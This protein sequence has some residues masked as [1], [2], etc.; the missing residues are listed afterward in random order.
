[1]AQ[2]NRVCDSVE[3]QQFVEMGFDRDIAGMVLEQCN[4]NTTAAMDY[5]LEMQTE[6]KHDTELSNNRTESTPHKPNRNIFGMLD[7][8]PK[9]GEEMKM[10]NIFPQILPLDAPHALQRIQFIDRIYCR[11]IE[12]QLNASINHNANN[13]GDAIDIGISDTYNFSHFLRDFRQITK[14]KDLLVEQEVSGNIMECDS[15]TCHRLRR[16]DRG[17]SGSSYRNDTDIGV[18]EEFFIDD[19]D[20]DFTAKMKEITTQRIMDS[21]HCYLVHSIRIPPSQI[22]EKQKQLMALGKD[23]E[24]DEC[25]DY[26]TEAIRILMAKRE[27][28]PRFRDCNRS[29]NGYNKFMTYDHYGAVEQQTLAL[30]DSMNDRNDDEKS[31][32]VSNVSSIGTFLEELTTEMQK[33]KIGVDI[34]TLSIFHGFVERENLDSETVYDDLRVFEDSNIINELSSSLDMVS[35]VR[36]IRCFHSIVTKFITKRIGSSDAYS[37]GYRFFYWPF[38]CDNTAPGRTVF[39]SSG[40]HYHTEMNPGYTLGDWYIGEKYANF[41]EEALHNQSARITGKQ[42]AMTWHKARIQ[43]EEW[44]Q[45]GDQR[46]CGWYSFGQNMWADAY[47][48]EDG[49]LV[50]V[51]HIMALLFYCDFTKTCGE[52]CKTFRKIWVFESDDSLKRRHSEV[53]IWARLLRELIECFGWTMSDPDANMMDCHVFYHGIAG[54]MVFNRTSNFICGPL[55]TSSGL[56]FHLCCVNVD[57]HFKNSQ[58]TMK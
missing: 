35:R 39:P 47:G 5:L 13:I 12:S 36:D 3:I 27:Q 42:W 16:R 31:P 53:A 11:W 8:E 4:F 21:V 43:L 51:E 30:N 40:M 20:D 10:K 33:S 57:T 2:Q 1:M 49:S 52:F 45:S 50:T 54:S 24:E 7:I 46:V 29:Q 23:S 17:R 56:L 9:D 28:L 22:E 38:Y 58:N 25:H 18:K 19:D 44:R 15:S 6:Q 32:S 37:S 41:K 26:W 34:R 48:L 55:S 14:A